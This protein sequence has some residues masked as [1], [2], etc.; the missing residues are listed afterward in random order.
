MQQETQETE[1]EREG[2]LL[3]SQ[4]LQIAQRSESS[5]FNAA[6]VVAVQLPAAHTQTHKR[7]KREI[8]RSAEALRGG[9]NCKTAL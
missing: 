6:D 3:Y 9:T 1:E 2:S 4:N 8:V 5:I 7:E